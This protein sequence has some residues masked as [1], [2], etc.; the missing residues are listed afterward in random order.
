MQPPIHFIISAPRSGSTWLTKALGQHPE[1][2]ATEHRL[3]GDFAE[4]WT[5]NDGSSSPRITF[6]SYARAFSVHY[7]HDELG[8]N[9]EQFIENMQ[10]AFVNFIVGYARRRSGC[11]KVIDKVTPYP[12][13]APRVIHK[14]RKLFPDSKVIQLVRDGRDVLTSGTFDWLLKDAAG[15]PRHDFFVNPDGAKSLERFFDDEVIQKWANNW[16]ETLQ[17]F[18]KKPADARVTY[19]QMK[20]DQ[21][22]ELRTIFTALQVDPSESFVSACVES[23]TFE[24]MSGRKAGE[25]QPTAKTR[26]GITGDWRN[27][28]T[29]RDAELF[30]DI[31][32]DR[33][34]EL[35]YESSDDWI[36]DCPDS[37]N[38]ERE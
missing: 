3:F 10:R 5:N 21:A 35:G 31:T 4:I 8:L 20:E 11:E 6:D 16:M 13:T 27:Y 26:K 12:G 18:D 24:K 22:S 9:R 7:F 36:A 15:T 17:I 32:S 2:F 28:F 30:A 29:K 1:L 25:D 14:I 33:L 19:E 37:L 34:I 38:L 23:A